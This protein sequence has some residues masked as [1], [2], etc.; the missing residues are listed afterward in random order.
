MPEV[1]SWQRSGE[2]PSPATRRVVKELRAGGVVLVPTEAGYVL[3]ASA[4]KPEAV[5][6]L[7]GPENDPAA[8]A[9]A[10]LVPAEVGEW[11]P[12]AGKLARRLARRFWPGPLVLTLPAQRGPAD[13]LPALVRERLCTQGTLP[14]WAPRSPV[15]EEI[16]LAL[17]GPLV[18]RRSC[19]P[20]AALP[21][22]SGASLIVDAGPLPATQE[23]SVVRIDGSRWEILHRGVVTEELVQRQAACV[24]V[25]VCTGNTCRSPMAEALFKKRL[26]GTLGVGPE[27]L[28]GRGFFVLSAGL[29]AMMEGPAAAEAVE[30]ARQYGADLS[31]HRSRPLGADLAAQADY[32][33]AMTHSHLR[34]LAD[35]YAH[36]GV[37]PRLL[38]PA[39]EDLA[40]PVGQPQPVYEACGRQIWESLDR[41]LEEVCS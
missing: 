27:E 6:L 24:V 10:V 38:S 18:V 19:G 4:Q 1:I 8:L 16:L 31:G 23:P 20:L 7:D 22:T 33:I 29:A 25:F 14:L 11:A 28:P 40:D 34:A 17:P 9:L 12:D 37:R 41:L 13:W 2:F 32:L 5:A 39:G 35:H 30:V 3:A 36:L 15:V 26:A 21:P